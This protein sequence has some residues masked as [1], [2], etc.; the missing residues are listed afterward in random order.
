MTK[1]D[2]RRYFRIDDSI[3]LSYQVIDPA[4]LQERMARLES[5]LESDF[6]VMSSLASISQQM[7]GILHKIEAAQPDIASY[8]KAL[9]RKVDVLGRA[10]LLQNSDIAEQ[11][12]NHVNL[13]ASGVAFQTAESLEVGSQLELKLLL[14]PSF[15]GVLTFAEVVGCE[16][17]SESD[18]HFTHSVRVNFNHLREADRDVIIRHVIR[19]QGDLLRQQREE[20]EAI[21]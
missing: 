1:N 8:L 17:L 18:E 14:F 15:T 6:T 11:P 13:S 12:T 4:E 19:K 5:E 21:E 2:R 16:P 7:T 10:F 3:S 9:D 20:R